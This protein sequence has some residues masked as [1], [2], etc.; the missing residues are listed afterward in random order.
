MTPRQLLESLIAIPSLTPGDAGCLDILENLLQQNNFKTQIL[1]T[2]NLRSLY[3]THGTEHPNICFSG[4]VDVVPPGPLEAWHTD[5]FQLIESDG[6]IYGRGTA[7]M[8]SG[9]AAMT[10]AAIN[11]VSQNPNHPGTVSLLFTSDEEDSSRFGTPYCLD[12]IHPKLTAAL[13][14]EPTSINHLG[15]EFKV[16][17]RGSLNGILTFT[18]KQG[19]TAYAHLALNPIH[20]VLPFL[21][22][23][24]QIIWDNGHG[25]FPPT[26]LQ[27]ANLNSGVGTF[28][29]TP[30]ELKVQ[31]NVRNNPASPHEKVIQTVEE[32]LHKHNLH[33]AVTWDDSAQGFLTENQHLQTTLSQAIQKH[34]SQIPKPS[35]SGG[36]SDAR[37]FALNNI[38]VIE[39]GPI[40]ATIHAANES[41]PSAD[42]DPLTSIYQTFLRNYLENPNS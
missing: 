24:S 23:L 31:F 6:N 3:A 40:N 7:D 9:V 25:P 11:Y 14:G 15:D 8:K 13:V 19:H 2:N 10:I 18:G 16:G 29:V 22:E 37:F 12:Q 39:F 26:T 32:L 38:P 30:G 1:E 21:T 33:P 36:T 20:Q 28:N 41:I 35:T 4:H 27:I 17:R 34:T 42:L 5:P